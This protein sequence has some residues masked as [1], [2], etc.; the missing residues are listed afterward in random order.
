[1]GGVVMSITIE[2]INSITGID[3]VI[4]LVTDIRYLSS[5]FLSGSELKYIEKRH[6]CY[7][8]D[9]V[10]FQR[11]SKILFVQFVDRRVSL[12]E[13]L[14]MLR[15]SG[16][17]IAVML[18]EN[19]L[20]H[21]SISDMEGNCLET[22]ALA[23]GLALSN[24]QFL[25]F[26]NK[27]TGKQNSLKTL[28][29]LSDKVTDKSI[30]ELMILV[31]SVYHCRDLVNCPVS[32]LNSV[33]FAEEITAM[34]AGT[35]AK[36]EVLNLKKIQTLKMGGV[37]A[38]NKGSIDPPTFTIIE[39]E[40]EKPLNTK[41]VVLA[42]KGV[43][44]DTGG[45]NLKTGDHMNNMKAD[46]AGAAAIASV[47]L[48]AVKMELP[49]RLTALLPSTDNRTHGNAMVSGDVIEMSDGTTVEILNTDAEGRLILADALIYARKY[50]PALVVD[51]ATLTGSAQRAF[52]NNAIAGM[53][54][55]AGRYFEILKHSS[56]NVYE[57]IA[58]LPMWSDYA[59]ELKSDIADIKNIS[60][61]NAGA[62]IAGKFLEH[63]TAYPFIHLDI[64]GP[65]FYEKKNSYFGIGGSGYG[66]RLLINFLQNFPKN[67]NG[68]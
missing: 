59:D 3:S 35:K 17:K 57:R 29:I 46:M 9:L 23:E 66:V 25:K 48:A 19:G 16:D 12:E 6:S 41:P 38:V 31:E 53:Q 27:D 60:G 15:K 62:I 42:G 10:F 44:Y 14:E 34:F 18:N 51:L 7:R 47:M 61:P 30:S 36:V 26:K 8:K 4:Y 52:G 56:F 22:I 39:W 32:T 40:P 63:F 1:M 64:A 2:K 58:E 37:L 55:K 49:L 28:K 13:R 45:M 68:H 21:I 24:Y 65:A 50:N 11:D 54:V 43:T 20:K 33:K 5:D 67:E